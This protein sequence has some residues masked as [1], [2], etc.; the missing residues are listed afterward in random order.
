MKPDLAVHEEVAEAYVEEHGTY[1][2]GIGQK[3]REEL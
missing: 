1:D 3:P 2:M